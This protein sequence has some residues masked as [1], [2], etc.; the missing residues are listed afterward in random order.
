MY[1]STSSKAVLFNLSGYFCQKSTSCCILSG[2]FNLGRYPGVRPGKNIS[3]S[4]LTPFCVRS[5]M[6]SITEPISSPKTFCMTGKF[7]YR[8]NSTLSPTCSTNSLISLSAFNDSRSLCAIALLSSAAFARSFI[9][10]SSS[11]SFCTM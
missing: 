1:A 5:I 11:L 3:S 9:L 2:S 6:S 4:L 10:I 8:W 7:K